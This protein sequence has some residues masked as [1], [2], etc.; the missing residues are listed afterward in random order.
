MNSEDVSQLIENIKHQ[1]NNRRAGDY[2]VSLDEL[3]KQLKSVP[4]NL[5]NQQIL[6]LESKILELKNHWPG[7]S[8]SRL[9]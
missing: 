2:S 7:K 1:I 9:P 5:F 6:E 8:C 3:E 4:K